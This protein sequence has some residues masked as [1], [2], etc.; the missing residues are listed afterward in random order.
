MKSAANDPVSSLPGAVVTARESAPAGYVSILSDL[1]DDAGESP[2]RNA[3]GRGRGAVMLG[4]VLAVA[5]L[6]GWLLGG[7]QSGPA[8]VVVA[9]PVAPAPPAVSVVVPEEAAA[10]ALIIDAPAPFDA[11]VADQEAAAEVAAVPAPA[12][13]AATR[14]PAPRRQAA[15]PRR[16][17]ADID[18]LTAI[19]QQVDAAR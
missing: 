9:E 1:V 15:A 3:V 17:D 5:V 16:A 6:A 12:P 4:G 13:P 7:G 8:P 11:L 2:R 14:A 18:I 19:V 10:A